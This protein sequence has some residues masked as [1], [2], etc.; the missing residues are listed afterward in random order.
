MIIRQWVEMVK[1]LY[2]LQNLNANAKRQDERSLPYKPDFV[3]PYRTRPTYIP[4]LSPAL[5][6]RSVIAGDKFSA[7]VPHFEGRVPTADLKVGS[8]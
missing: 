2:S 7:Q 3:D 5:S 4:A 8:W 1:H 6:T